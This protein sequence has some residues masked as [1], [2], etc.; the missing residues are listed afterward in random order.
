MHKFNKDGLL[1][2]TTIRGI[3]DYWIKLE[4]IEI[5]YRPLENAARIYN[6]NSEAFEGVAFVC[7][8][9]EIFVNGQRPRLKRVDEEIIFWFDIEAQTYTTIS[10]NCGHSK[11]Q[12][13]IPPYM[14]V[15]KNT[16]K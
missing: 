1:N 14:M 11:G 9:T 16:I 13:K 8:E 7:K 4:R 10:S 2:L 12:G 15:D 3:M 6:H 5:E